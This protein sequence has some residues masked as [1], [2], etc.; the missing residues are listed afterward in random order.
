M[1]AFDFP[2]SPSVNDQHTDNGITF[3]WDGT[4]WKRVSAT[5]A[6]GPTGS[7]GS[8]GA[9]GP[10]GAQGQKGAQAYISDAAPSSGI[11]AGDLWWDSDSGDFSI[12]FNDGS[13]SQWIEVGSTGP[14]GST[15][16]Q[17]A[18][19]S[20]G[21]T[22]AQ[23]AAGPTGAQGATGST[24]S[25]G[26]AGSNASISS[27]A[28][29]R[30]ITG[31][32]G[33]NLVGESTFTYGGSAVTLANSNP[34]IRL[35]DTD[36]SK[37]FD[38]V[39]SGGDA[40]LSANSSGMNMVFEV[41][42]S[43]RLR[44]DNGGRILKGL[45]TPRGN[46]GNNASGVEY[47]FQIEGTSAIAAGLSIVRNSNDANDGGIV[48]GKTRATSNGGNTVV[49]A[50]DDLG[51]LTFAGND[52]ST[53][54]FGAEIFAEVQSGV[55]NDDMPADLIFKTNGGSTSTT[56]RLRIGS[57]GTT[58]FDPSAGGTLKI[59]GSSAHTSKIV[60]ADNGG[61]GNGNC[62]VE[63]GDGSDFFTILSNGNVQFASGK[64]VQFG[65]SGEVLDSY[66]EGNWTPTLNSGSATSYNLQWYRKIGKLVTCYFYLY[67][68]TGGTSGTGINIGGLPFAKGTAT[69]TFFSVQVG[70]N[71]S[72]PSGCIQVM[73]RIGQ[74]GNNSIEFKLGYTGGGH[75]TMT[76]GQAG[77]GH[78]AAT[79]SYSA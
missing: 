78:F 53:M 28:D 41:T 25:Q 46:Y 1:A 9:T 27:N 20:G 18:T 55:G 15:G 48:L 73:G 52:G 36:D 61:T 43:E 63:G 45:T 51:N 59:G 69:E 8:Q 76:Y 35:T 56:E 42:G 26:A 7:T 16:A 34:Q 74:V 64:G 30:I 40:Y 66:E 12:Y 38:M 49:Q 29:N 14:T 2:N 21:S 60:I 33:T 72:L 68:F 5:G 50:G 54:L 6:Q 70:G 19:G 4:V 77:N 24:G 17:G 65:S 47:G 39:I 32:S 67:N 23:G 10:T 44:I 58:T 75:G 11:A 31:G 3:K 62:L 57:D 79:F 13:G 22:G 71:P 37:N